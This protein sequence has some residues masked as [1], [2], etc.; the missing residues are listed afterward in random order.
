MKLGL[1]FSGGKDSAWAAWLAASAG[2]ELCC[3]LTV[4]SKNPESHLYHTPNIGLTQV[5][6]EA[7]GLPLLV[8]ETA[9]VE[10]AE[11]DDL[12]KLIDRVLRE[13]HIEGIVTG[14]LDSV[15]QATR[16]QRICAELGLALFNPIWQRDQQEHVA[17]LVAAG[18]DIAISGIAAYPLGEEWLGRRLDEQRLAKLK[19]LQEQHAISPAGEG[20]EL[21][22]LA[23]WMPG[24]PRR[25]VVDEA[26]SEYANHAGTWHVTKTHLEPVKMSAESHL[27]RRPTDGEV[28]LVSLCAE[29]LAELEYVRPIASALAKAGKSCTVIHYTKLTEK[30]I[31]KHDALI[32][33]GTPLL[34][35]A[36]R[37]KDWS[38]LKDCDKPLLGICAGMQA[39]ALA[40]GASLE[41]G[42]EIGMTVIEGDGDL[43]PASFQAYALHRSVAALPDGFAALA[44]SEKALHAFR[45]GKTLGLLF[46]PEVRHA[47]MIAQL[48]GKLEADGRTRVD[49]PKLWDASGERYH[50][51]ALRYPQYRQTNEALV[52]LATL[53]EGET[54]I[55]LACG[56]G[57]T[58]EEILRQAPRIR[59][60][61]ALDF[62]RDMVRVAQ[63]HM[64]SPK[65]S[66]IV[67]D[68]A[69]VAEHVP[70]RADA[71]LCNSAFWQFPDKGDAL[72]AVHAALKDGGRFV[73]NLNQQFFDFG[74]EEPGQRAVLDAI[75]AELRRRGYAP[76]GKLVRR[77]AENDVRDL[78]AKHGFSLERTERLDCG[79]RALEDIFAFFRIPATATFFEGVPAEEREAILDAAYEKVNGR[80]TIGRN[81]WIVFVL[82]KA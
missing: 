81:R 6:A 68:A 70:E 18:C 63:R 42:E 20:G 54:A 41:P 71:V 49:F 2:H 29:P 13:F 44:R 55:D 32:L 67:A 73:F 3:L 77:M 56:T 36:F 11:L 46:H 1:L 5:Q 28:L 26:R 17:E 12:R 74:D 15:Y 10:E 59:K 58:T 75:F 51:Y 19:D 50:D 31:S 34:D 80:V 22:T 82:R 45:K 30:M 4:R 37:A 21:E 33:S 53:T 69:S 47:A 52:R 9:G 48:L 78:A 64:R 76:E 8:Q 25:I 27:W 7:T 66:F 57:L 35:D 62:S 24:W 14:A 16:F 23:L 40:H 39:I 79:P 61:Y 72:D 65:A 38:F 43:L 60:V